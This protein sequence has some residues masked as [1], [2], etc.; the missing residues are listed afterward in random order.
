MKVSELIE[1]LKMENPNSE[2]C[3]SHPSG[4]YWGTILATSIDE[5]G[6]GTVKYS[7]YHGKFKVVDEDDPCNEENVEYES[8]VLLR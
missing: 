7:T 8:V 3:F 6:E 2:V 4:D 1:K 5:V